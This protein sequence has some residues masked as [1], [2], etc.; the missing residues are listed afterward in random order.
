MVSH[1]AAVSHQHELRDAGCNSSAVSQF[2]RPPAPTPKLDV[3]YGPNP[4]LPGARIRDDFFGNVTAVDTSWPQL[5]EEVTTFKIFLDM[6]YGPPGHPGLA[7]GVGSTDKQLSDLIAVL[8]ARDIRTGV[9]VGGTGWGK[10]RCNLEQELAYAAKEQQWVERWLR[11]GGT[12]DSLTT[13]HA[14]V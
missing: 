6:L 5:A 9:E 11:L 1:V 12:I 14:D 2:C 13:D 3:W 8:K 7:P 4:F 10:G